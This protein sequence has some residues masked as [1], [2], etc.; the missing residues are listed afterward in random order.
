MGI[1]GMICEKFQVKFYT[2]SIKKKANRYL[3]LGGTLNASN[4]LKY[5]YQLLKCSIDSIIMI[6]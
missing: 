2:Y 1:I 3:N 5:I 4:N 6:N